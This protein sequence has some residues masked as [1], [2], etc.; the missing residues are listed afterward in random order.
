MNLSYLAPPPRS[1]LPSKS[2]R[3]P[4]QQ[5]ARLSLPHLRSANSN[6]PMIRG[7]RNARG[8]SQRRRTSTARR[9]LHQRSRLPARCR[10]DSG[11]QDKRTI[12][13]QH[14][15]AIVHRPLPRAGRQVGGRS[16]A[17]EQ[18]LMPT[19]ARRA[20]PPGQCCTLIRIMTATWA[21]S[22]VSRC[23]ESSYLGAAA[24]SGYQRWLNSQVVEDG[25]TRLD[26][27]APGALKR[28]QTR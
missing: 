24:R 16:E 12:D 17:K 7:S 19:R 25:A 15:S 27:D 2:S 8:K 1:H 23:D 9:C 13:I 10:R 28:Q 18:H 26:F 14:P 4:R 21:R 3:R 6:S 22:S 20:K 5:P 11:V